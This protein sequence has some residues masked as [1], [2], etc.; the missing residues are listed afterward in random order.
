MM[1]NIRTPQDMTD[2]EAYITKRR[3]QQIIDNEPIDPDH[4]I[5][6]MK[7]SSCDISLDTVNMDVIRAYKKLIE[8]NPNRYFNG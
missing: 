5:L 4:M 8:G 6:F 3:Q 7:N 2:V 1:K